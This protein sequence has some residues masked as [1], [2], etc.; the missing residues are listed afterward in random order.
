MI[1]SIRRRPWL[2]FLS[3]AL[4]VAGVPIA[5]AGFKYPAGEANPPFNGFP[6][7]D[8]SD[9]Q[10]NKDKI[11][12][13][14]DKLGERINEQRA[15][16]GLPPL[17]GDELAAAATAK[18]EAIRAN[19]LKVIT[20]VT[21]QIKEDFDE[22]KSKCLKKLF[23]KG[24]VCIDFGNGSQGAQ[25]CDTTA[26]CTDDKINISVKKLGCMVLACHDPTLWDAATTLYEETS[27]ALQDWTATDANAD[28]QR[29][30]KQQKAA[31]NEKDVDAEQI[32]INQQIVA[33]LDNIS[34]NMPHG[35]TKPMAKAVLDS[36]AAL[37]E[38]D[39]KTAAIEALKKKAEQEIEFDM[40]TTTCYQAA[41]DIIQMFLDGAI[42][43]DEMNEQLGKIKWQI[44][45]QTK[46]I[47]EPAV[48]TTYE[49]NST[50]GVLR[51][52]QPDATVQWPTG[53]A[54]IYDLE[55]L[56]EGDLL[57]ISGVHA[58]GMGS[59]LA[60]RDL[61]DDGIFHPTELQVA[62]PATFKLQISL[63]LFQPTSGG[64]VHVYDGFSRLVHP[65]LDTGGD[66][67]PD[68]LGPG[69]NL[70]VPDLD[71]VRHFK[72][73][74]SGRLMGYETPSGDGNYSPALSV[75][76]LIDGDGDGF[77]EQMIEHSTFGDVEFDPSPRGAPMAR[78]TTLF[79]SAMPGADLE[80][81]S[82][83]P[84]GQRDELL[85]GGSVPKDD[86]VLL[87]PLNRRLQA[88]EYLVVDD[89]VN[90]RSS[91]RILAAALATKALLCPDDGASQAPSNWTNRSGVPVLIQ[92]DP[93]SSCDRLFELVVYDSNG[94]VIPSKTKTITPGSTPEE[95]RVEV[96]PGETAGV[97]DPV[98]ADRMGVTV[99]LLFP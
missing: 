41:K 44:A 83:D 27:H 5:R 95:R 24:A 86:H 61:D 90:G 87:L 18:F 15:A 19:L 46:P 49:G 70:P 17:M 74:D 13:T 9:S 91:N 20:L 6:L 36:V 32:C 65:L 50:S 92:G 77:Y 73:T 72:L 23:D 67:I 57:L 14:K 4:L 30:K 56:Q 48:E 31:C 34:N 3:V 54:G 85:G 97:R 26:E 35:Q 98:D 37:P 10:A 78:D 59:I 53:L 76:E 11:Q 89:V 82:L 8:G 71:W 38:G 39:A 1:Q 60:V 43:K 69:I 12:P 40:D 68:L 7:G 33:G 62:I 21:S 84:L 94:D 22:E 79:V 75:F 99:A 16:Q 25:Y 29:A 63:D 52:T 81:W 80:V 88:N 58:D 47:T 66:G 64:Q 93:K 55:L 42:T 2:V 51:Q 96:G 28:R 45:G